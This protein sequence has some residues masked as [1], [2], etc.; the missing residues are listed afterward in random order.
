V[1]FYFFDYSGT[2]KW[3]EMKRDLWITEELDQ[4]FEDMWDKRDF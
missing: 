4:S 3:T 1:E 2:N